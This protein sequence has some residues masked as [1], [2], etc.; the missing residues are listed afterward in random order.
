MLEK[1]Q[2]TA[3]TAKVHNRMYDKARPKLKRNINN[4]RCSQGHSE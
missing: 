4:D 3:R 1:I 2:T